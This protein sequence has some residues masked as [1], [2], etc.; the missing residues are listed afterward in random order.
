MNIHRIIE[1]LGANYKE[2]QQVLEDIFNEVSSI[3]SNISN[4]DN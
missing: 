4:R 2:D 1:D 3:A